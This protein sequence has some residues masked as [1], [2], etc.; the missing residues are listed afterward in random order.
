MNP[1]KKKPSTTPSKWQNGDVA[2]LWSLP[3]ITDQQIP[4]QYT[5]FGDI[6]GDCYCKYILWICTWHDAGKVPMIFWKVNQ[7]SVTV[8]FPHDHYFNHRLRRA[9]A[10]NKPD[11]KP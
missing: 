11:K 5:S 10:F 7:F 4:Y 2:W 6:V 9:S 3:P 8:D 1:A